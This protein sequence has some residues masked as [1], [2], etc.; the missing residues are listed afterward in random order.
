MI[1]LNKKEKSFS[2]EMLKKYI[3]SEISVIEEKR[4][5]PNEWKKNEEYKSQVQIRS[6][7]EG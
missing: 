5:D 3:S 1:K 2:D 4:K 6:K 7:N